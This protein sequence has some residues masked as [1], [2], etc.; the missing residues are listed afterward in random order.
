VETGS[1]LT[2]GRQDQSLVHLFKRTFREFG[3]VKIPRLAAALA[4]YAVF[5]LSPL[6]LI[7]IS[8]AGLIFGEDAAQGRI[9][10]QI[11]GTVGTETAELIQ[12]MLAA[13]RDE[14]SGVI[15][16]AIG[17]ITLFLGASALFGH[18]QDALNT[19]WKAQ[20]AGGGGIRAV[21][22]K[23]LVSFGLVLFVGLLLILSMLL[24]T[25]LSVLN[26]FVAGLAP[27]II[28]LLHV[29]NL[30]VT[31]GL[32]TL[33][34]ATLFKF[35]PDIAISWR[36]VWVGAAVTAI[37]FLIGTYLI[38]FYLGRAGPGS[39][40]GAAGS[41]VVLLLWIYYSAQIFFFGAL[42]TYV[43]ASEAQEQAIQFEVE[44]QAQ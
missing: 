1:E 24:T 16:L 33:L 21:I 43:F 10:G 29:L 41:L 26:E 32:I 3:A 7:G 15:A 5:S 25:G 8:I 4:F 38:G 6:L 39:V 22:K 34:F 40:F 44:A 35:L 37:L 13:S 2:P 28:Y 19:I 30:L 18:L 27:G 20:P 42:F 23:R 17:I 12:T 11:E 14:A 9:V 31:L 36:E